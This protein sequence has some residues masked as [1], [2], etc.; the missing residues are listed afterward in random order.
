MGSQHLRVPYGLLRQ[1]CYSGGVRLSP[2]VSKV[3]PPEPEI[4]AE[5]IPYTYSATSNTVTRVP[6]IDP[7]L[8]V[9]GMGG[10]VDVMGN[11][12][13]DIYKFFKGSHV[14]ESTFFQCRGCLMMEYKQERKTV[15]FQLCR[16]L[17]RAIEERIKRDKVCV[18]CNTGTSKE[19]WAIPL[20]SDPCIIKWRF[21]IP[22][23]WVAARRIVLATQPELLKIKCENTQI[24]S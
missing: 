3:R 20:C 12:T 19:R 17:M 5:A 13:N 10:H 24:N 9:M 2:R 6:M 18:I 4:E 16:T 21:T 1:L 23:A 22:D 7:K 8:V 14:V 15:H 11:L